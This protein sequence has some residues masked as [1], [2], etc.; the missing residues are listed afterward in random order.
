MPVDP[1]GGALAVDLA[2]VLERA[3]GD[4]AVWTADSADL[5]VNLVRWSAGRG[6]AE[7]LNGEVD[8]LLVGVAGEAIVSVDGSE[9]RLRPGSLCLVPKGAR[10]SIRA[11]SEA[12][13]YLTC[14][15]RRAGLM[16]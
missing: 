2:A 11:G 15:R 6:V 3:R 16:P 4:G 13:A 10:R 8:V 14:H 1:A 12:V 7:H 5:Q 9:C